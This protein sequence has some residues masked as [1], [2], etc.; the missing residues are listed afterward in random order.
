MASP[1]EIAQVLPDTLPADFS[2]WDSDDSQAKLPVNSSSLEAARSFAAVPKP[3]A[4]PPAPSIAPSIASHI[5]PSNAPGIA[6]SIAPRS[7]PRIAPHAPPQVAVRPP[8]RGFRTASS[9]A[10]DAEYTDD[11][12]YFRRLRSVSALVDTLPQAPSSTEAEPAAPAPPAVKNALRITPLPEAPPAAKNALRITPLPEAPP[13][14]IDAM[15]NTASLEEELMR[16][17]ARPSSRSLLSASRSLL[18]QAVDIEDPRSTGRKWKMVMAV[19]AATIL[20]AVFQLF[21]S[22]TLPMVK[23]LV[24]PKPVAAVATPAATD[25]SKQSPSADATSG[26]QPVAA[27][28]QPPTI[29][30]PART[31]AQQSANTQPA[32]VQAKVIPPPVQSQMMHDQLTAPNLIPKNVKTLS[33]EEAPPAA[34]LGSASIDALGGNGALGSVFTGQAHPNIKAAKPLVISAGV[35]VGLIVKKVEPAY[36]PIAKTAR[37]SGTVVIQATITKAGTVANPHVVS[38][39][40]MLRQAA[41]EAVKSWRYRPYKLN[42]EPVEIETTVNVIFT[43]G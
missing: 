23:H 32:A 22:G 13:I 24:E 6:P 14:A 18:S 9:P 5:A 28:T 37:V 20:L 30:P 17:A 42:N 27:A 19:T 10:P 7:A 29:A 21:H 33:V 43:L 15:R 31:A 35:A 11:E 41:L 2:E 36:P 34:G 38:G 16:E 12:R 4:Q 3:H 25:T 39:P 40:A 26:N 1:A 8:A